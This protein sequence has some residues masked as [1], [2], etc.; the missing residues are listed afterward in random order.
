[1]ADLH[2]RL[3]KTIAILEGVK[4]SDMA[5][6]ETQEVVMPTRYVVLSYSLL[7]FNTIVY[8]QLLQYLESGARCS[9][10]IR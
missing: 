7:F 8:S 10:T 6:A 2:E 9:E 5:N 4:E 3:S 1:M